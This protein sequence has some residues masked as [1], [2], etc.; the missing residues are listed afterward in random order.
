MKIKHLFIAQF[1]IIA[2]FGG[3]WIGNIYRL[4]QCDFAA[5]YKGE[6]LHFLGIIPPVAIVTV[7][8]DDK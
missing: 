7:W 1:A 8:F 4:A 6:I 5:P 2:V 3:A